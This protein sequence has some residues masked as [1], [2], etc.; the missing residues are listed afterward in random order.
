MPVVSLV[1]GIFKPGHLGE[2]VYIWCD[3]SMQNLN[4]SKL[5]KDSL[6][7]PQ[8]RRTCTLNCTKR[9]ALYRSSVFHKEELIFTIIAIDVKQDVKWVFLCVFYV[10]LQ[11]QQRK[12]VDAQKLFCILENLAPTTLSDFV[13]LFCLAHLTIPTGYFETSLIWTK[14]TSNHKFKG[15]DHSILG[16]FSTDQ[17]VIELTKISKWRLQTIE[18]L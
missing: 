17:I 4:C 3:P 5:Y 6:E 14:V 16:N 1:S 9:K 13:K 12:I 7:L 18:E 2:T 8:L 15:L 10:D 11:K